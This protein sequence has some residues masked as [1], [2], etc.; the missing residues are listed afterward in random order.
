MKVMVVGG[1]GREHAIVDKL[2]QSSQV[3]EIICVPGNAG[4]SSL[5]KCI[6]GSIDDIENLKD[7]AVSE[8]VDFTV[9]GPEVPLTLGIV[10]VFEKEGLRIFGPSK[11]AAIIE[12]SKNFAKR[13]LIALGILTADY[14]YFDDMVVAEA[15]LNNADLSYPIVIKLD[16]LASGKGVF[17]CSDKDD[18]DELT[19]RMFYNYE[20]GDLEHGIIVEEFL[21]G[22]EVSFMALS[23][24]DNVI[25]LAS[26]Q[27]HKKLGDGDTGP[28][29]GGM[30]AASPAF[31]SKEME[32]RIMKEI[33]IPVVK[34]MEEKGRT[35]K[36]VLYAGLMIQGDNIRVLE[37]NCRLGDPEAQAVLMRL[38]SD[39]LTVLESTVDGD[40]KGVKLKWSK[41]PSVCIVAAS[42]GYPF[43]YKIDVPISIPMLQT[44]ISKVY[45]S[46]TKF[47]GTTMVTSGGRVL[48]VTCTGVSL[49]DAA[50]RAYTNIYSIYFEGM[51]YRTDIPYM[52][53]HSIL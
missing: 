53:K 43:T 15:Y 35:Y 25:P 28:N 10:D 31:L 50:R 12:G 46:G 18:L 26:S 4:I 38:D 36:G 20:F 42:E 40:L 52:D 39:L 44:E 9:V 7:I 14:Y 45:H 8:K 3:S 24:G 51:Y 41:D 34:Y 16:E 30:G 33:M 13:M 32:D 49:G 27:D 5:A 48:G 19:D 29:T 22:R 11:D 6:P 37:F 23:D 47:K 21:E 17:I 1:G 2:S